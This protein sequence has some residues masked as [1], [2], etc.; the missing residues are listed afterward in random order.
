[1]SS[2]IARYNITEVSFHDV[3]NVAV[4]DVSQ[5]F[6]CVP[7]VKRETMTIFHHFLYEDVYNSAFVVTMSV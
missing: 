6:A 3:H 7:S 1:M 4:A 2:L 5:N